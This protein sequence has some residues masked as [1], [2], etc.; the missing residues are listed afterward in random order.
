MPIDMHSHYYGGLV[1]D[2]RKRTRRPYVAADEL[3]RDVLHAM[4]ASTVMSGGYTDLGARL[5]YLDSVG[6]RT[7]LMTF[8]GALGVDAEDADQVAAPIREFNDRLA[9]LCRTSGG[10]FVGLAGLPLG[11]VARAAAE[12][13]RVRR[14]RGLLGAILPGGFFLQIERAEA[15]RPVFRAANE[16]GGLLMVH[17]G[18]APGEAPPTPFRDTSVYRTSGLELQA[19]ISHMAL[20]LLFSGLLDEFPDV[21][22]QVVNLGGT[23][24]FVLE[25]LQAIAESRGLGKFPAEKL[26]RLHYD[27]ASLGPRALELAVKVVGADRIMLGTD[28]PIFQPNPIVDTLSSADLSNED[29]ALIAHGVASELISR[30]S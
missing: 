8:P 11:D 19:S 5:T 9:D 27:C 20:T 1:E 13:T 12:L 29:R 7:Q 18:L 23:L 26:R 6:I 15:L 24:P 16:L 14:D 25:R 2:L 17:P 10:R 4:T 30:L 21:D 3:G 22:V 28:Y